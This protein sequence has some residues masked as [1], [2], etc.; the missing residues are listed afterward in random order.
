M[1]IVRVEFLCDLIFSPTFIQPSGFIEK[2]PEILVGP[3]VVRIECDGPPE[4]LLC[5]WP[6]P[7]PELRFSQS[8]MGIGR[9]RFER[10]RPLRRFCSD[11]YILGRGPEETQMSFCQSIVGR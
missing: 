9:I 10:Y 4:F 11:F 2:P 6:V 3:R 7:G 1:I 5:S 8:D